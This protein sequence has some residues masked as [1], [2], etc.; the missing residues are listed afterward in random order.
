MHK[1]LKEFVRLL[2]VEFVRVLYGDRLQEHLHISLNFTPIPLH[3]HHERSEHCLGHPEA[4]TPLKDGL[5]LLILALALLK[6][7]LT[8]VA[9]RQ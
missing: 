5:K 1:S 9:Y 7:R 4:L 2:V 6:L 3:G 8:L